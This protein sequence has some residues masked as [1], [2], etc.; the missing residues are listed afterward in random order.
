[1]ENLKPKR[2]APPDHVVTCVYCGQ[3]YPENTPTHGADVAVLT[4]HIKVCPKHPMRQCQ[5]ENVQLR[6]AL[7][8]AYNAL[9]GY[10][11]GNSSPDLAEEVCEFI[12]KTGLVKSGLGK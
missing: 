3:A 1:M 2:P 4:E 6:R 9:V 10:R 8:A 7:E 11:Y 12:L 5:E